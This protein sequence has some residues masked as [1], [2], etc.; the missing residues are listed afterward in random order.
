MFI[1]WQRVTGVQNCETNRSHCVLGRPVCVLRVLR[2]SPC[3]LYLSLLTS[4]WEGSNSHCVVK[5]T[6]H[7]HFDAPWVLKLFPSRPAVCTSSFSPRPRQCSVSCFCFESPQ[8]T[9]A[10]APCYLH[11]IEDILLHCWLTVAQLFTISV[12]NILLLLQLL[13]YRLHKSQHPADFLSQRGS[14]V[15]CRGVPFETFYNIIRKFLRRS[16]EHLVALGFSNKTAYTLCCVLMRAT[17][18]THYHRYLSDCSVT[19]V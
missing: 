12:S 13:R 10:T 14:T 11:T 1:E 15:Y 19:H 4:A 2:M 18:T 6:C 5:D 7:S 3:H 8:C 16:I 17:W 9:C